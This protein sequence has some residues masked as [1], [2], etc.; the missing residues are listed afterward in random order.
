M[1]ASK[2][3]K[4]IN[5]KLKFLYCQS[6]YRTP[7]YRR[8]LCNALIQPHF[9]SGCSSWF[10]VLK[11]ILKLKLQK[12]QSKCTRFCLN[13]PPRSHIDS[14]HFRKTNW[15]PVSDRVEYCTANTVFIYWNGIVPGYIHEMFKPLL[16]RYSTRLQM[17]LDIPLRKINT[18]QKSLSFLGPKI[19]SKIDRNIK[20]VRT[21]SSFMHAFKKNILLH[22]Q[23]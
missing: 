7:A 8:L 11:K 18:G 15:L 16:C 4:E 12:A 17:A 23:N 20:N 3:L 6:R 5:A 19:W 13:L 2:V 1:I 21:S 9:D 22:L 14:S 10:P